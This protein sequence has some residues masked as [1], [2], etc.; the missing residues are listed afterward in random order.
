MLYVR[1]WDTLSNTYDFYFSLLKTTSC[2]IEPHYLPS[3]EY[4]CALLHFDKIILEKNE[5]YIK[6]SFRNRC[7]IN[8]ANGVE[9]LVVPLSE[10]HGKV[11]LK[12]IRIDYTKKWQN[13]HWRGIQSAYAKAPFFEHYSHALRQI[14]F[15][16]YQ[17]LYDLN[18]ALLSF[19]LRSMNLETKVSETVSYEKSVDEDIYDLRSSITPKEAYSGRLYY[20]PVPYHQVFGNAFAENLSFADLLFSEGPR[21][22]AIL[23]G[24][25]KE[26]L[27]K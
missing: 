3:L 5:H 22:L 25:Q 8:T 1:A 16:D 21:S 6:Q 26:I 23:K 18:L 11:S 14:I 20:K 12:E 7:Y 2:L 27:N 4:F 24:S 19:C 13:N 17:F 9:M 10:K 15:S